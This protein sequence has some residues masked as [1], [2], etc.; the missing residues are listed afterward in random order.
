MPFYS[1]LYER[2]EDAP[3]LELVEQPAFFGDLNLDQVV[4][5]ITAGRV[6]H[7]LKPFYYSPLQSVRGIF[8]R[9][10]IMQDLEDP[11]LAAGIQEF[12]DKMRDMRNH[13]KQAAKL[14]Q[15]YQKHSWFLD[16]VDIYCAAVHG[17]AIDLKG[18]RISSPGLKAWHDYI[19]AYIDSPPFTALISETRE[20]KEKFSRVSYCLQITGNRVNVRSFHSES[21]YSAQVAKTFAKFERKAVRDYTVQLPSFPGLNHVEEKILDRVA[22][23]HPDLF[24]DLDRFCVRHGSYLDEKIAAFD[25]EIQF[26]LS[27]LDYI[28]VL[29]RAGLKFCYPQVSDHSKDEL[30]SEGFDLALAYK[31]CSEG[32]AV[33]CNDYFLKGSERIL[34][35]SGPNQGGKTTFARSFGQLHYLAS[36]GCPVPGREARLFLFDRLFTH[37]EKEETITNLHGKLQDDLTRI[38]QILKE[39]T[40]KSIIIVNEIFT[41]TTLVDALYLGKKILERIIRLDALCVCVTFIDELSTLSEKTVSMVSSVAPDN[42]AQRTFK[43]QRRPADGLSYALIIAQKYG[44]SYDQLK[45]RIAS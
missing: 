36:L 44:I 37:F 43:I 28:A 20:L 3:P 25:R 30:N 16:A 1:I 29:R 35:V 5:T 23:L 4:D 26:Y 40:A 45:E 2:P 13:I 21:D 41:S 22:R 11:T 8:Y 39:S 6:D 15:P 33:V 24:Q 19:A 14:D 10:R 18:P 31:L 27:Y 12:T 38:H 32:L 34:V 9:Q 7:D 17:L 42:P